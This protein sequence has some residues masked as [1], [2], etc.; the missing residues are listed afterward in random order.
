MAN[1]PDN[2]KHLRC[3][4][5]ASRPACKPV[6]RRAQRGPTPAML[7]F[8][9]DILWTIEDLYDALMKQQAEKRPAARIEE[10]LKIPRRL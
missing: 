10:L 4:A 5:L 7:A 8:L 2:G 9:V 6:L 3:V 1:L